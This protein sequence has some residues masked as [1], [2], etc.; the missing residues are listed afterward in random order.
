[1]N[2]HVGNANGD[3]HLNSVVVAVP[4]VDLHAVHGGVV[5]PIGGIEVAVG[6]DQPVDDE[7]V[8]NGSDPVY[9][10]GTRNPRDGLIAIVRTS[11]ASVAVPI[12]VVKPAHIQHARTVNPPGVPEAALRKAQF[13]LKPPRRPQKDIVDIGRHDER[14]GSG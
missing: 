3:P 14:H 10:V 12:R 7:T 11:A 6:Y 4:A 13:A 9:F 2:K 5:E 1:M 8:G